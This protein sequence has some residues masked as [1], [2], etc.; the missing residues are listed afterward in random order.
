MQK[1][2]EDERAVISLYY[3]E[4]LSSEEISVITGISR[5]NVKVRLFRARQRMAEI[6]KKEEKR[7]MIYHE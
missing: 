6:I 1:L 5:N 7:N 4:E 3:Y 2:S